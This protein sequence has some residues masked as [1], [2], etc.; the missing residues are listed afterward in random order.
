MSNTEQKL[1]A[2]LDSIGRTVIGRILPSEDPQIVRVAN[3][4]LAH[5]NMNPQNNQL[6]LQ[7]LP[8]FF[9]EF[10]AN[11]DDQTVWQYKAANITLSEDIAYAPQFVAQ[12]DQMFQA[13]QVV[14]GPA[15]VV[16]L[17]DE[18]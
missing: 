9:K 6:Q 1:T 2:F 18:E 17:F 15:K 3:P 11:R 10:Q 12:Y 4:A 5:I 8:L 7:L 14:A 13:A 16:K